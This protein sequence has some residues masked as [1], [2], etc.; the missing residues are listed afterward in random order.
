MN[1][2]D[3]QRIPP[4]SVFERLLAEQVE[5]QQRGESIDRSRLYRDHPEHAKSICQFL[6]DQEFLYQAL[7]SNGASSAGPAHQ[8]TLPSNPSTDSTKRPNQSNWS[9]ARIGDA[10]FPIEFG[11]YT[12]LREIDRGGMGIVFQ[13]WHEKLSRIVALKIIRSGELSNPEELA[14]FRAEAEASA[15]I[16]HV[17]IISIFEVG[18]VH[19]LVYFTMNFVDGTDLGK[20]NKTR[21]LGFKELARIMLRV[22][23]AVEAAHRCGIIHRDLKPS[24]ILIDASGEPYLIDFGLAKNRHNQA[25]TG[26]G[27]ILGTPA[28]MAPEQAQGRELSAATDV[29]SLGTVMY[30]LATG[31]PPFSGPTTVDVLLQVLNREP[32]SPR[33]LDKRIPRALDQIITRA[34]DKQ[35]RHRYATAAE[36]QADLQQFILDEPITRPRPSWSDQ[37]SIWW[38][39]QPVLVSHLLGTTFALLIVLISLLVRGSLLTQSYWI[40]GLL[41]VW[42]GSSFVFQR[43][44]LIEGKQMQVQWAWTAFDVL[45][46]TWL[47]CIAAPPRGLLMI[48]YPMMIAASAL[49]YRSRF[50]LFVTAMCCLG[51]LF[52]LATVQDPMWERPEFAV[53][54][55][56]GLLVLA[57]CLTSMIRKIRG[58]A[59]YFTGTH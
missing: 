27:Q 10:E 59:D 36:M 50:V 34:M 30:E 48:G 57:L 35:P 38:R 37:A 8:D 19:G 53:I 29:Y 16:D 12:L 15:C 11:D 3:R 24:N 1:V 43:M 2:D 5:A 39:R 21:R 52:I 17:N 54:Y 28:Y 32:P 25:L 49:F 44:T 40:L 26:T 4:D 58:L 9:L 33:H 20:L 55:L 42:A 41:A 7:E 46:Y 14:R 13:A 6:D 51:F 47:I 56:S 18:E 22:T 23:D 45:I 31:Q